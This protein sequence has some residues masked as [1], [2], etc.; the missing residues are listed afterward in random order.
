MAKWTSIG[1]A[2]TGAFDGSPYVLAAAA[3]LAL[4]HIGDGLAVALGFSRDDA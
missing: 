4:I 3:V 1:L 2:L